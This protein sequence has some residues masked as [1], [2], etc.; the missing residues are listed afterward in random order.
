MF[1]ARTSK[2][3][4]STEKE[5]LIIIVPSE[6][7]SENKSNYPLNIP[8]SGKI[9]F[10]IY[11]LPIL[12]ESPCSKL[13]SNSKWKNLRDKNVLLKL[14]LQNFTKDI[15]LNNNF[16][17]KNEEIYKAYLEKPNRLMNFLKKKDERSQNNIALKNFAKGIIAQKFTNILKKKMINNIVN[18]NQ[19][20]F[21]NDKSYSK[22][23]KNT[24]KRLR[25]KK[26]L[27]GKLFHTSESTVSVDVSNIYKIYLFS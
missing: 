22:N 25:L 27:Q 12:Q 17:K 20:K 24:M 10:L 5:K 6:T 21:I 23:T 7:T 13:K 3:E 18:E 1:M 4:S 15:N 2:L 9:F 11:L 26:K 19:M 8:G 16:L 14:R